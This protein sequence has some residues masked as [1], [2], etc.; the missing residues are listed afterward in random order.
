MRSHADSDAVSQIA[1]WCAYV[2]HLFLTK[3]QD[4]M[5]IG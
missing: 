1:K 5:H 4:G 2:K 3:F